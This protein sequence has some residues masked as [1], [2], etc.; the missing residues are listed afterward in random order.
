MKLL[1]VFIYNSFGKWGSSR[2]V[3]DLSDSQ[4]CIQNI[5]YEEVKPECCIFLILLTNKL[6]NNFS[7]FS[8]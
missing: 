5:K 3:H 8:V 2:Q 4:N 1:C 6:F 7:N